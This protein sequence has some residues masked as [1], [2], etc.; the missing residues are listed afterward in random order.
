MYYL[1]CFIFKLNS[2]A[3]VSREPKSFHSTA[4]NLVLN[5][6]SVTLDH[7]LGSYLA[8]LIEGDGSIKVP[9]K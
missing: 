4:T 9:E 3:N 1:K 6:S 5:S 7:H 2:L 8:G